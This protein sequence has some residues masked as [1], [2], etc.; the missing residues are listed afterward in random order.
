MKK[1]SRD[2]SLWRG[3][4]GQESNIYVEIL[5]PL[6]TWEN[7]WKNEKKTHISHFG[8]RRCLE[9]LYPWKFRCANFQKCSSEIICQSH[10]LYFLLCIIPFL[11]QNNEKI[12]DFQFIFK[13]SHNETRKKLTVMSRRKA[14][15]SEE[16]I[17]AA[18]STTFSFV[19]F[20]FSMTKSLYTTEAE[21]SSIISIFP[22]KAT[23]SLWQSIIFALILQKGMESRK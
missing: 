1:S 7:G 18:A 22:F 13:L 8:N 20:T 12:K 6:K 14:T 11:H 17:L 4:H 23:S 5:Y 16:L 3:K 21:F 15:S 10:Q 19:F 9:Y 2:N